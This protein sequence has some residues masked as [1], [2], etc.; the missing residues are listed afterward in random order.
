MSS[1]RTTSTYDLSGR[2]SEPC[3]HGASFAR[4]G[5]WLQSLWAHLLLFG[6]IS[7][8]V[9]QSFRANGG[10]GPFAVSRRLAPSLAASVAGSTIIAARS[11]ASQTKKSVGDGDKDDCIILLFRHPYHEDEA[12]NLTA[13]SILCDTADGSSSDELTFIGN[14][15]PSSYG[16]NSNLRIIHSQS[17]LVLA[18][19]GFAPDVDH[20]LNVAAGRVLAKISLFDAPLTPLTSSGRSTTAG[21]KSIDPHR[22]VREEVSSM[23]VDAASMEG[24]RPFGTQIYVIGQTTSPRRLAA[25]DST[26]E[27]FTL[28]PSGTWRSCEGQLHS[29]GRGSERVIR[30]QASSSAGGWKGALE[31]ALRHAANAFEKENSG[32]KASE[33][34]AMVIFGTMPT[35]SNSRCAMVHPE[36]INTIHQR[37]RREMELAESP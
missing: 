8:A 30:F 17:G 13:K 23:L 28:D 34:E 18:A 9:G 2:R 27:M 24:G 37:I 20:I 19:V 1:E 4:R 16:G 11:H 15:P 12:R 32:E 31:R 22:L 3:R 14:N 6:S 5:M 35:C 10:E 36:L 33:F 26:L 29:I 21:G 25:G 7:T